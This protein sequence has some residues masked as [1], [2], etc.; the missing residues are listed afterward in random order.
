MT[1]ARAHSKLVSVCARTG[2]SLFF[3][4][5]KHLPF[6][7]TVLSFLQWKPSWHLPSTTN[8]LTSKHTLLSNLKN[9]ENRPTPSWKNRQEH[10]RLTCRC[11]YCIHAP[12][13]C[14]TQKHSK[15]SC[16]VPASASILST[17]KIK[18]S[19]LDVREGKNH[20]PLGASAVKNR[21]AKR[22]TSWQKYIR[23]FNNTFA[24][25]WLPL[26]VF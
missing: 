2:V 8:E 6:Q 12:I 26:P 18:Q 21:I 17:T 4:W 22:R 24:R 23:F 19:P 7:F 15:S 5:E 25:F 10:L 11:W 3:S 13:H 20:C 9:P 1:H 14:R 16:H